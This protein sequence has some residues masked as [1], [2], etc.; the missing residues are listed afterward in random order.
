MSGEGWQLTTVIS[1][2]P[3]LGLPEIASDTRHPGQENDI[4]QCPSCPLTDWFC[5]G[6]EGA[7][8]PSR[9]EEPA[10]VGF[11]VAG[12]HEWFEQPHGLAN[13][14]RALLGGRTDCS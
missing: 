14:A 2:E 5:N 3:S 13:M 6:G 11:N 8:V 1:E 10:E 12:A 4:D 9:G 7:A